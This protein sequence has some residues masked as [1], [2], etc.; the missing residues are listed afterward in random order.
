MFIT[1][2]QFK[3]ALAVALNQKKKMQFALE[4]FEAALAV[5]LKVNGSIFFLIF[6]FYHH[7]IW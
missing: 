2:T 1:H 3:I 4:Q 5:V 6:Q 7:S